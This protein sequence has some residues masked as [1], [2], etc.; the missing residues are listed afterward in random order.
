V[1]APSTLRV[2]CRGPR[3]RSALTHPSNLASAEDRISGQTRLGYAA[4]AAG[5]GVGLTRVGW[6]GVPSRSIA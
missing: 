6:Y 5:L 3:K 2:S 1:G 4:T